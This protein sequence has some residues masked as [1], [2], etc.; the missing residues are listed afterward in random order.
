MVLGVYMAPLQP[1]TTQNSG[2]E[3]IDTEVSLDKPKRTWKRK[4][5]PNLRCVGVRELGKRKNYMMNHERD[6]L[7]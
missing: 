4:V 2:T 6:I 1:T 5:Y 7:E 3:H